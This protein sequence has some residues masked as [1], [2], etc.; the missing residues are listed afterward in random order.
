MSLFLT[1]KPHGLLYSRYDAYDDLQCIILFVWLF[2]TLLA[3]SFLLQ[4]NLHFDDAF[5]HL[6]KGKDTFCIFKPSGKIS[7]G[8][9]LYIGINIEK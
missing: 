8:T 9:Q 1:N 4:M 2:K 5:N 7:Y 3:F 6:R